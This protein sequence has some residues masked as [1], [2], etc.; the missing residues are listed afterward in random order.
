MIVKNEE[1]N[2]ERCL[3][4]VGG[5]FDEIII[6]DTGSSDN[7]K[8]LAA[9]Y[10]DKIYDFKWI[11]DFSAARNFSF[12]KAEGDYIIWLDADDVIDAANLE[13]FKKIKSD[14]DGSIDVYMLKYA[15][16]FDEEGK[17][18]FEY[19]RE[20]II[21]NDGTFFWSGRVHEVI[22]PHGNIRYFDA[23][24]YHKKDKRAYTDRNLKIYEKQLGDGVKFSPREQYYYSRE[25]YY[26]GRYKDAIENFDR[27]LNGKYG[28]VEN[29]IEACQMKANCYLR[30]GDKKLA[31]KSLYDSF[32][33]DL[34]RAEIC[35]AIG[36]IFFAEEEY[37]QSVYWYETAL[38]CKPHPERGGFTNK[39]SYGFTP[40]MQLCVCYYR[41]GNI[42]Q[43]KA[44]NDRA[45][46]IKPSNAGVL[47]NK[48]FFDGLKDID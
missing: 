37:I 25:L 20:R 34:P 1:K 44:C 43:S 17:P 28:W 31:L 33:Y 16:S 35:C 11:D 27:F 47:Y 46:E 2:I 30:T 14:C 40:L 38:G 32:Y 8:A 26:N 5:L 22:T 7:T 24:V 9:R 13:K 48:K 4:S 29:K 12:S 36:D 3:D 6:A 15:A 10:T 21:K 41:L 19:Y 45:A 23:A 42:K 18:T 39:D